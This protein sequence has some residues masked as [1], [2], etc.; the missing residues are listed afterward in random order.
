M[1]EIVIPLEQQKIHVHYLCMNESICR[2]VLLLSGQALLYDLELRVESTNNKGLTL[3]LRLRQSQQRLSA[4]PLRKLLIMNLLLM[5]FTNVPPSV[6]HLALC[7]GRDRLVVLY[8]N[9]TW[10][11]SIYICIKSNPCNPNVVVIL[12]VW[13]QGK[14]IASIN[15]LVNPKRRWWPMSS[16]IHKKVFL[17]I[18][19]TKQL[20][21]VN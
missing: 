10:P 18:S 17:V 21:F 1:Y 13:P 6:E 7:I 16:L 19:F 15:V 5:S 12:L 4:L 3:S 20:V 11:L 8:L 14:E 2:S 9:F